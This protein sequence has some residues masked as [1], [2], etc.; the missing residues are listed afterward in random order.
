MDPRLPFVQAKNFTSVPAAPGSVGGRA[1]DLIVIH[2][3]EAP[4]LKDTAERV[5]RYF[6]SQPAQGSMLPD[7]AVFMAG[8]SAHFC[9]D[10]YEAIQCVLEKDVAWHAPG[11]NHN[12]IGIEHAGYA[13]YTERDWRS[14]YEEKMLLNSADLCAALCDA[15]K[16][17]IQLVDE[18]GLLAGSRG[19]TTH[20]YVSR[21]FK[22]SDHTD[23]GPN[24]PLNLYLELVRD[25][26][27]PIP[28]HEDNE[29]GVG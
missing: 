4:E 21:A 10:A 28:V 26:L 18:A 16:I 15:Y 19:I 14:E 3:M 27:I 17:P 7:G 24:F 8:S 29:P 22:K 9:V 11:A 12:G 6:A 23:P 2:D 20:A 1:I 13:R 5:A 25:A